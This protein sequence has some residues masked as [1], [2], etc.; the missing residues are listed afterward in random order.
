MGLTKNSCSDELF[1]TNSGSLEPVILN[2]YDMVKKY[3][4]YQKNEENTLEC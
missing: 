4:L 1:P 2:V 3:F